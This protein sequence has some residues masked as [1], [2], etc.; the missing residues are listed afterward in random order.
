M[1]DKFFDAEPLERPTDWA[2]QAQLAADYRLCYEAMAQG[3][4]ADREYLAGKYG[5]PTVTVGDLNALGSALFARLGDEER[6]T[7]LYSVE[8]ALNEIGQDEDM[9]HI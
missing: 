7:D 2:E 5:A 3:K 8:R 6:A 4:G 1:T 9:D